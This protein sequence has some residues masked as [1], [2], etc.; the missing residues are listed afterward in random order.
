MEKT[1][2]CCEEDFGKHT[3]ACPNEGMNPSIH[4]GVSKGIANPATKIPLDN[5]NTSAVE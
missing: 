4:C 5:Q 3:D 2:W 1:Y